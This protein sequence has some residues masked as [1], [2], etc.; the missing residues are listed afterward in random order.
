MPV[1]HTELR[2]PPG[3]HGGCGCRPSTSPVA[4]LRPAGGGSGELARAGR[5]FREREAP[6][7]RGVVLGRDAVGLAG[8]V[9]VLTGLDLDRDRA[10][11]LHGDESDVHGRGADRRVVGVGLRAPDVLD[12]AAGRAVEVDLAAVLAAVLLRRQRPR[13]AAAAGSAVVFVVSAEAV[14]VV[15][16]ASVVVVSSVETSSSSAAGREQRGAH[17]DR[18][19][20][21]PPMATTHA[22][23]SGHGADSTPA[24]EHCDRAS[25]LRSGHV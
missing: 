21:P 2:G 19:G 17:H 13:V 18:R 20:E 9:G 4:V 7:V 22:G 11:V 24:P 8:L 5:R 12:R 23:R 16:A 1:P 6:R 10:A 14:V 3:E 25:R 15:S